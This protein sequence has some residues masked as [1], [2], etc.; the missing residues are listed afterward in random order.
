AQSPAPKEGPSDCTLLPEKSRYVSHL[1]KARAAI[2]EKDWPVAATLL[3]K[4]LDLPE[5]SLVPIT[6]KDRG[7]KEE[8]VVS[9]RGEAE[10]R[11]AEMPAAGREAY[12][13]EYGPAA[14]ELL[15]QARAF[16]DADLLARVVRRFLHTEA[17]LEA[18]ERLGNHLVDRGRFT[19]A[20]VCFDGLFARSA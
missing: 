8:A 11:L 15:R 10:R 7:G 5:D 9:P 16:N 6:R 14:A 4:I 13:L 1:D 2:E 18:A 17:G 12:Q 19:P 3:Q 20:A